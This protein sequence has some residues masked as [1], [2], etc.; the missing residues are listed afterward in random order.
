MNKEEIL[1][2]PL[3]QWKQDYPNN[4]TKNGVEECY[5][6]NYHFEIAGRHYYSRSLIFTLGTQPG[7]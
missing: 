2:L 1:M 6:G 5:F 4:S 3:Y 7:A